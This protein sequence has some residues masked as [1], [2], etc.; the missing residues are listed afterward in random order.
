MLLQFCNLTLCIDMHTHLLTV[1]FISSIPCPQC[2]QLGSDEVGSS[3]GASDQPPE[4]EPCF[5]RFKYLS[6][7]VSEKL[8]EQNLS[9]ASTPHQSPLE[10]Q[11]ETYLRDPVVV[12]EEMDP[13]DFWVQSV[14]K[15]PDLAPIAIDILVIPA[16]STP[17]ERVFS[18]A[19]MVSSGKRNRL[20][21][22]RL[23]REVLIKKNKSFL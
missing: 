23:E 11:V 14:D 16:S 6:S 20:N 3:Q 12:D 8:K 13:I 7:M 4:A 18:T 22:K 9:R 15:Y 1:I 2:G 10:E 21:A 19:G 17:I 5:K